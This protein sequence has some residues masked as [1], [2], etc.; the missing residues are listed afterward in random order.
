[1]ARLFTEGF[2]MN[3]TTTGLMG[4]GTQGGTWAIE[5]TIKR[6]GNYSMKGTG[7]GGAWRQESIMSTS[8]HKYLRAYVRFGAFPAG[9]TSFLLGHISTQAQAAIRINSDGTLELWN[10]E[11]NVQVGS[12]SSAL[13]VD[14]WYKIELEIDNTTLSATVLSAR[15]DEVEFASG[16]VNHAYGCDTLVIN[17]AV[18]NNI[19]FDDIAIND[20]SGS[21][22]T[23]WPGEGGI[24]QLWPN[25]NGDNSDWGGSDGDSTD[26][27]ALVDENPPNDITDYV[28]ENVLNQIDDYNIEDTPAAL[29]AG[30]TIV[31]VAVG[32]RARTDDA[33]STDPD[34]VLRIKATASGTVEE[35]SAID[36]N[37]TTW[38]T[39]AVSGAKRHRLILYDLP[40]ASTTAWSKTT[41]DTAQIGV[42]CSAGDTNNVQVSGMWLAVEYISVVAPI[43]NKI[44]QNNQAVNRANTY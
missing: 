37:T 13:S 34:V 7:T 11:D 17:N 27:Y 24:I 16:T 41:L 38:F 42:R 5:S 33:T 28:Q 43:V 39:N 2:E 10:M 29:G 4:W 22:E 35:S 12:D 9:L 25:A 20:T 15:I 32:V 44:Y 18:V 31:V 14:Q 1:M 26:N 40:G 30:D 6:S 8:A 21:F 3:T 36:V 23:S 19:Y